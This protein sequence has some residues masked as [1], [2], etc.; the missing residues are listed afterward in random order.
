MFYRVFCD[1]LRL[2]AGEDIFQR[3]NSFKEHRGFAVDQC[4]KYT[5]S[6]NADVF[7][8]SFEMVYNAVCCRNCM[9]HYDIGIRAG[10]VIFVYDQ[11]VEILAV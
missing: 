1:D 5:Y 9:D 7:F 2:L 8:G 4:M 3:Q 6:V 11:L 10:I